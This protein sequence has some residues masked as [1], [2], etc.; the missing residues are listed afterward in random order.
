MRSTCLFSYNA[1]VRVPDELAR[2]DGDGHEIR[3]AIAADLS[4]DGT[5]GGRS[6][7]DVRFATSVP[8]RASAPK[9]LLRFSVRSEQDAA[10]LLRPMEPVFLSTADAAV[11]GLDRRRLGVSGHGFAC[12][13]RGAGWSGQW[14]SRTALPRCAPPPRS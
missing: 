6:V 1:A 8:G 10:N 12:E 9:T 2:A 4:G 7:V 5:L 14:R 13:M 11:T 3:L